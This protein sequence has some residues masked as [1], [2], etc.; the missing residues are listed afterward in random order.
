ML[1]INP[2]VARVEACPPPAWVLQIQGVKGAAVNLPQTLDNA[3]RRS[4][5]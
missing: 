1:Y 5:E 3:G 4:R 2:N